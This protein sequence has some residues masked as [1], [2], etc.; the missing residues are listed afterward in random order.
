[1]ISIW[2]LSNTFQTCS[3]EERIAHL[4]Y[5]LNKRIEY[6]VHLAEATLSIVNGVPTANENSKH[7]NPPDNHQQKHK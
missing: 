4:S 6:G 5:L 7:N 1:M 2:R 3:P